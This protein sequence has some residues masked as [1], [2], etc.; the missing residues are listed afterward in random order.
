MRPGMACVWRVERSRPGSPM[1]VCSGCVGQPG[2]YSYSLQPTEPARHGQGDAPGWLCWTCCAGWLL[3]GDR[4]CRRSE[5]LMAAH[6]AHINPSSKRRL[7]KVCTQ[8][9]LPAHRWGRGCATTAS[10]LSAGQGKIGEAESGVPAKRRSQIRQRAPRVSL[11]RAYVS[12]VAP[13]VTSLG[14][15]RSGRGAAVCCVC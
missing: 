13:C 2:A 8:I 11:W 5:N 10:Q 15:S 4:A 12:S 7:E 3:G 1:C 14:P 6:R 9:F